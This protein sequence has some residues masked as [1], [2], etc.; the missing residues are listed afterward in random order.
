MSQKQ[1][2]GQPFRG[3]KAAKVHFCSASI[4]VEMQNH[5]M[6]LLPTLNVHSQPNELMM[7][8]TS[9]PIKWDKLEHEL[10]GYDKR[11]RTYLVNGFRY[12]FSLGCV[13]TP[14]APLSKNHNSALKHKVIENH[15][16]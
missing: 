14:T 10:E 8:E 15:I 9:T 1:N 7:Q 4:R 11:L 16:Q 2:Y 3:N 12:V 6:P 13:E 5:S